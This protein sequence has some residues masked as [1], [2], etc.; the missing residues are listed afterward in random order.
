M[1]DRSP[2]ARLLWRPLVLATFGL[3]ILLVVAAITSAAS[4]VASPHR[5]QA[6]TVNQSPVPGIDYATGPAQLQPPPISVLERDSGLAP[7]RA[8]GA[9][10]HGSDLRQRLQR[11]PGRAA[12]AG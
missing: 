8:C 1:Y 7:D 5:A 6:S 4:A 10:E 11:G 2:V 9:A 3:A 12:I